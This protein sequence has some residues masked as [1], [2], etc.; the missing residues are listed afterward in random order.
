M[1]TLQNALIIAGMSSLALMWAFCAAGVI[2]ALWDTVGE[3]MLN[4]IQWIRRR[5]KR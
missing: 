3:H 5:L 1:E 2:H 4:G